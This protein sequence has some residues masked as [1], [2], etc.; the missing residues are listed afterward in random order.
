[1]FC[2]VPAANHS[3]IAIPKSNISQYGRTQEGGACPSPKFERKHMFSLQG[4]IKI[5]NIKRDYRSEKKERKRENFNY[6]S[7]GML[8]L[9]IVNIDF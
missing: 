3:C 1:M 8:K 4:K 6:N 5:I 2:L 7:G 9:I